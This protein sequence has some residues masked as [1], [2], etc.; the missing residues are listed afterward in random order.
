MKIATV[1]IHV[2][3]QQAAL[4]F[5][6]GKLGWQVTADVPVG[7]FR[8]ITLASPEAPDGTQLALEPSDHPAVAP[9]RSALAADGIPALSLAVPDVQAEYDRL[10]ALGVEFTQ[11]PLS[12][13]PVTTAIFDDTQGNLLQIAAMND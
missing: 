1:G 8:W 13:G 9:Y 11:A 10:V 3:D 6:T 7:E 12:M 4:D 2:D 5:Y